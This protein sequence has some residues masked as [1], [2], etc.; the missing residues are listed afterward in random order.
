MRTN[1]KIKGSKK[2][3]D[4]ER[5]KER[6]KHKREKGT[7]KNRGRGGRNRVKK[8]GG[9]RRGTQV[10]LLSQPPPRVSFSH[11]FLP[12]KSNEKKLCSYPI[13]YVCTRMF[14]T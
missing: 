12:K 1:L 6:K 3:A 2:G 14:C 10:A 13:L 7:G 11:F 9:T 4:R 5:E 8:K